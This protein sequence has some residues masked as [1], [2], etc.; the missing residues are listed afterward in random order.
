VFK[1]TGIFGNLLS[2]SW[3]AL[4]LSNDPVHGRELKQRLIFDNPDLGPF[5]I[6][7]TEKKESEYVEECPTVEGIAQ[8]SRSSR[9]FRM[10]SA[11]RT[12]SGKSKG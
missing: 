9:W 8:G 6:K 3:M 12:L 2:I 1:E 7:T 11:S 10:W 4:D 5:S